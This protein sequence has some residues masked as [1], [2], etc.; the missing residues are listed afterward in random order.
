MKRIWTM[1]ASTCV[2]LAIGGG[3]LASLRA[4]NPRIFGESACQED[5]TQ[6]PCV[7]K[8][9]CPPGTTGTATYCHNTA[10]PFAGQC[11]SGYVT[12]CADFGIITC[13]N[14]YYCADGTAVTN[15]PSAC[16]QTVDACQTT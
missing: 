11:I 8:G 2:V 14:G 6:T 7:T 1:I 5:K 13:G 16:G 15:P 12:E 9:S 10:N 3:H 4:D